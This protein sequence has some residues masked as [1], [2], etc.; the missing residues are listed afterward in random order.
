[1]PLAFEQPTSV[2]AREKMAYAEY[3]AGA[4]FNS[5]SLGFVHAFSHSLSA[6]FNTPH[7]LAN[8]VMLPFIIDFQLFNKKVINKIIEVGNIL[9]VEYKSNNPQEK[10]KELLKFLIRFLQKLEIPLKLSEFQKDIT[11]KH[12]KTMIPKVLKDFTGVTGPMQFTRKQIKIIFNNA[13]EGKFIH[14]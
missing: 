2:E 7:G 3:M 1:L 10:A 12:I 11:P 8:A 4:A 14:L 9:N 13:L 6:T 5:A